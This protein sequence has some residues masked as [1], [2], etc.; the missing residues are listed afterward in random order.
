MAVVDAAEPPFGGS[1]ERATRF[2]PEVVDPAVAQSIGGG[3][4]REHF[5]VSKMHDTAVNESKPQPALYRIGGHSLSVVPGVS[6][7]R[8]GDP[9]KQFS[10]EEMTKAVILVGEPNMSGRVFCNAT[11]D[12]APD[13]L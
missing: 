11:D 9:L 6:Q 1:P 4:R 5:A 2:E 8:P 3:I 7:A 12:P 13:T 10:L